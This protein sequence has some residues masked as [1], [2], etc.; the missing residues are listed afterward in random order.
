MAHRK[1]IDPYSAE[2]EHPMV[3]RVCKCG[4]KYQVRKDKDDGICLICET[5]P[6]EPVLVLDGEKGE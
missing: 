3:N 4:R 6:P 1:Q 5:K 2:V